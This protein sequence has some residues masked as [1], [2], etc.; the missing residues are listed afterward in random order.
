MHRVS[1]FTGLDHG[2]LVDSKFFK[3]FKDDGEAFDSMLV[4]MV[5]L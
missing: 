2:R 3:P 4:I 5:R 1:L